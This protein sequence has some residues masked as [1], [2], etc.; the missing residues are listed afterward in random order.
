LSNRSCD[1]D[2]YRLHLVNGLWPCRLDDAPLKYASQCLNRAIVGRARALYLR[3]RLGT[4]RQLFSPVEL[5]PA[6][7]KAKRD[8]LRLLMELRN[9]EA[10]LAGLATANATTLENRHT[11]LK[12]RHHPFGAL[13]A[14]L[15]VRHSHYIHAIYHTGLSAHRCWPHPNPTVLP[16]SVFGRLGGGRGRRAY[17]VTATRGSF[18]EGAAAYFQS[19]ELEL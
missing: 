19:S 7:R 18:E 15:T 12:P 6:S 14:A 13:A 9:V 8:R 16:A 2:C 17:G 1:R 10:G 5:R 3:R 4:S 11:K